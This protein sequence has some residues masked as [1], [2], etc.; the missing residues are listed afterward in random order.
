MDTIADLKTRLESKVHGSYSSVTDVNGLIAEAARNV[1]LMID[2]METKR[3]AQLSNAI[4]DQVY[5]Y[6]LPADL[7][8]DKILDIR[9]QGDRLNSDAVNQTYS[10]NFSTY[11]DQDTFSIEMNSGV[12]TI[13]LN[14]PQTSAI[15][16]NQCD[17]ITDNGTWSAGS[18][19]TDL[20][21]DSLNKISGNGSLKFNVSAAG[22]TAYIENS[23]LSAQD[24]TTIKNDGALFVWVYIPN[25]TAITSV[26]LFWGSSS[27]NYWS[28]NV[29]TS[30]D[31]TAFVTGW[32]LLRFDWN[33]TTVVGTPDETAVDYLRV[34]INYDGTAVN[35]VRV[36]SIVA[37]LGKIYELVYYSK[38][39]FKS[40]SG[41][42]QEEPLDDGDIINLDVEGRNLLLYECC[43]LVG[44][45]FGGEDSSFDTNYWEGKRNEAWKKYMQTYKTERRKPQVSYY[46]R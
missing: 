6:P 45:E 22:S 14:K 8:G 2:P 12:K 24:L 34:T 19:A 9:P 17:S 36:D 32:N 1:L 10:K 25:P 30:Q 5:S 26:T 43:Y 4:Y 23:T 46:R 21:A 31:N 28:S 35:S 11:K 20:V 40:S 41:V 27:A 18:S 39:L 44:Q 16:L 15:V 42:W 37:Q 38:Y 7:K 3:V 13:S 29:T 33:T